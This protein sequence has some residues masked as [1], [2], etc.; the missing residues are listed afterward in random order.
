MIDLEYCAHEN[1]MLNFP[2]WFGSKRAP[3]SRRFHRYLSLFPSFPANRFSHLCVELMRDMS[4]SIFIRYL[5]PVMNTRWNTWWGHGLS[6]WGVSG[7]I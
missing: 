4:L 3:F 6:V 7:V 1:H 2:R 5:F